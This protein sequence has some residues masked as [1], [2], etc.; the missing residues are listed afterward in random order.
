MPKNNQK[1]QVFDFKLNGQPRLKPFKG[2]GKPPAPSL[3]FYEDIQ[4]KL[5]EGALQPGMTAAIEWLE[6]L[7]LEQFNSLDELL[8]IKCAPADLFA[9]AI[10]LVC[11][12][13]GVN[14]IEFTDEELHDWATALSLQ[15]T[16]FKL[17]SAGLLEV[18]EFLPIHR[19]NKDSIGVRPTAKFCQ[20]IDV[21][22]K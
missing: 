10:C 11:L 19:G 9:C 2:F 4:K 18:K 12:E 5:A 14:S 6:S 8:I 21:E 3:A 16:L 22:G 15:I 1:N 13:K 17:K 7:T 20:V